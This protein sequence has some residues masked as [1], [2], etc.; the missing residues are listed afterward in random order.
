MSTKTTSKQPTSQ[1]FKE[2]N[3]WEKI[4]RPS[5]P[6]EEY[7][8]KEVGAEGEQLAALYLEYK[9]Y[10]IVEM[11]W[12]SKRGEIDIVARQGDSLVLCE[13]K[14]RISLDDEEVFPELKVNKTKQKKYRQL[15]LQYLIDHPKEQSVRFDVIALVITGQQ[16]ARLRHLINAFCF[17]AQ[18]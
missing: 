15:A 17:D 8:N 2:F 16:N 5:K 10:E 3:P 18:I 12:T 11:N 1:S 13:V 9:G 14:T 7:N 4:T 6:I